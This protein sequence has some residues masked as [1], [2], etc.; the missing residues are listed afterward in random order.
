MV[1]DAGEHVTFGQIRKVV[2]RETIEKSV[3]KY[4]KAGKAAEAL[5][6]SLL[7]N[8]AF[9]TQIALLVQT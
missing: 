7:H 1:Y 9:L 2:L 6:K 3:E 8:Y 5:C 4:F